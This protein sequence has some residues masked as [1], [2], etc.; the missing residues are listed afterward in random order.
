MWKRH[1]IHHSFI[2]QNKHLLFFFIDISTHIDTHILIVHWSVMFIASYSNQSNHY[3]TTV[4]P[5]VTL[6]IQ[7]IM[8]CPH[9]KLSVQVKR[10]LACAVTLLYVLLSVNWAVLFDKS[11]ETK[12]WTDNHDRKTTI[13]HCRW[14]CYFIFIYFCFIKLISVTMTVY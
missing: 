14:K 8:I 3:S 2:S 13:K 12:S 6:N 9:S 7:S 10:G 1:V 4:Q 11:G 5:W